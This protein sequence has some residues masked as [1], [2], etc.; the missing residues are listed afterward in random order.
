MPDATDAANL[1]AGTITPVDLG[2]EFVPNFDGA[3]YNV[4]NW[5]VP[6]FSGGAAFTS[7]FM[8]IGDRVLDAP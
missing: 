4:T 2:A 6:A 3:S 7:E 1:Y 5:N 8:E